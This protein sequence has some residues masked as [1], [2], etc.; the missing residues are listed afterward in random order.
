MDKWELTL[1]SKYFLY[2]CN[3]GMVL[4]FCNCPVNGIWIIGVIINHISICHNVQIFNSIAKT[5]TVIS[6]WSVNICKTCLSSVNICKTYLSPVY[7]Y[8]T[9]FCY[10]N[11]LCWQNFYRKWFYSL[12]EFLLICNI[13]WVE[14]T[15]VIRFSFS[16][17]FSTLCFFAFCT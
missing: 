7:I 15:I 4:I 13:T 16:E 5:I 10:R 6:L 12:P 1:I 2:F 3:T 9:F 17:K 8:S 14:I 11:T